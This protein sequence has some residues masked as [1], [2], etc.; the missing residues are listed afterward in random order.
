MISRLE[1]KIIDRNCEALGVPIETLMDN[2]GVALYDALS[3]KF[4]DKK[5]LF[6]CGV[7]NNGGDGMSCARRIGKRATVALIYPPEAIKTTAARKQFDA[8][9]KKYVM[10][11]DISLDQY[12]VVVDCVLGVGARNPLDPPVKDYIKKLRNFKGPVVSTDIPTGFGTEMAVV[13][14]ITVTFH[15]LKDGMTEDN[16]GK[17]II[18]DIG[19]PGE[20]IHGVGIGDMLRYPIPRGDSHKGENGRLLVIGGGPYVGAPA[21]SAMA[22]QRVGVD[23]VRIVVPKRCFVPVASMTPTFMTYELPGDILRE[24]DVKFLLELTKKVD[25]VLIGPGLGTDADTMTAVREFV[26][27]CDKPMVVDADG[28]AAIASMSVFSGTVI[29]TPH[30]HEFEEFS[31]FALASCDLI[32][33]AKKRNVTM[34]LK[35]E[36]DVIACPYKKKINSSGTPAMTVGGT[37]DVLSGLVAGLLAKGMNPFDSSCLGAFISGTAGEKAFEL[38][39]YGMIA[40]DVIDMIPK[41]LIDGLKG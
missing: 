8:L 24:S 34:L 40:T 7:G 20:A 28:I 37:G 12:E 39:S 3:K 25:A 18:A 16:C 31:G 17:I 27:R 5:I 9:H 26:L 6:V 23:L 21:M 38:F 41:V 36:T 19:I 30:K 2:A 10:F 29:V 22:A 11:S 35:G 32:E 33:T 1:S 14:N 13:P 15:D 4:G